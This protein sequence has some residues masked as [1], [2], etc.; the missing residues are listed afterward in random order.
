[1]C[2]VMGEPHEGSNFD[3]QTMQVSNGPNCKAYKGQ[4]IKADTV[5]VNDANSNMPDYFRYSINR[6]KSK[7][8]INEQNT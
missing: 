1:M 8:G 7:S 3:F 6:Q 2:E 5:D 4:Q